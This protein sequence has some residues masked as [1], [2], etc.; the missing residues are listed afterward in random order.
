M[1]RLNSFLAAVII[2]IGLCSATANAD[3]PSPSP[4][5][6]PT[7]SAVASLT[8]GATPGVVN[9]ITT[10][11]D[12]IKTQS[13][14]WFTTGQNLALSLFWILASADLAWTGI[15]ILIQGAEDIKTV[16]AGM[17]S[18]ILAL[19]FFSMFIANAG[20]WVPTI[21]NGFVCAGWSLAGS[22]NNASCTAGSALTLPGADPSAILGV[23]LSIAGALFSHQSFAALIT[24]S[25]AV[26]GTVLCAILI[27]LGF[28]FIA[29]Q[30]FLALAEAYFIYGAG[31]IMMGFTGSRWTANL[32]EKY[33]AYMTNVGVKLMVMILV[34]SLGNAVMTELVTLFGGLEATSPAGMLLGAFSGTAINPATAITL[35]F[36]TYLAI[37]ALVGMFAYLT[38]H[39]PQSAGTLLSGQPSLSLAQV[40]N[41]A[42]GAVAAGLT[43]ASAG[44]GAAAMAGGAAAQTAIK[45]LSTAASGAANMGGG[46][47]FT[48]GKP[49]G[50][51]ASMFSA[52]DGTSTASTRSSSTSTAEP[53]T[54]R[55]S[56]SDTSSTSGEPAAEQ[57]AAADAPETAPKAP[58]PA[59][60]LRDMQRARAFLN[61]VRRNLPHAPPDHGSGIGGAGPTFR[62]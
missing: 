30:M 54:T 23:G 52:S 13:Q 47:G 12:T 26:I 21:I 36:T 50:S 49:A 39:I 57:P 59:R 53:S 62:H 2:I 41:V 33:I 61:M 15:Q 48:A 11:L 22:P 29:A 25:G 51:T 16:V 9:P 19:A 5:P 14:T 40:A 17:L 58:A 3:A 32:G 20:T 7:S 35:N 55:S 38:Y 8:G 31:I 45:G 42:R 44:V 37:V 18:K 4:V 43:A 24:N 27:V 28:A 1:T 60:D 10:I 46:M 6:T 34:V 56:V